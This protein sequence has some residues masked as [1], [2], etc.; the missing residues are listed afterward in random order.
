MEP[1]GPELNPTPVRDPTWPMTRYHDPIPHRNEVSLDVVGTEVGHQE[2]P[3]ADA[4]PTQFVS[5]DPRGRAEQ[6][7]WGRHRT[8]SGKSRLTAPGKVKA[9]RVDLV[10]PAFGQPPS[11]ATSHGW[12]FAPPS[13]QINEEEPM[14]ESRGTAERWAELPQA[15]QQDPTERWLERMREVE[16]LA[17]LEREQRGVLWTA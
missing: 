5:T 14:I 12:T 1:P 16:H 3:P 8:E 15:E 6:G 10:E 13:A 2:Q 4:P 11:K 9:T 7:T 17:R